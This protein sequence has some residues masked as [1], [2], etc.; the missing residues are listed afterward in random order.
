MVFKVFPYNKNNN[1][2]LLDVYIIVHG[3]LPTYEKYETIQ[4]PIIL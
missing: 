4:I 2:T 1:E 3:S